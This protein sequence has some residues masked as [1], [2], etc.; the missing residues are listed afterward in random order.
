MN[1]TALILTI[2]VIIF[3]VVIAYVSRFFP[4]TPAG[5]R[6]ENEVSRL[7]AQLP[8]D[9][10]NVF[11][12][13]MFYNNNRSTQIDHIVV[14]PF[15]VFV[16]ETKNYSGWISGNDR[17][18]EWVK[19]NYGKKYRFRNPTMQNYGHVRFLTELLGIDEGVF[20]S[21]VVFTTRANLSVNTN[22]AVIYTTQLIDYIYSFRNCVLKQYEVEGLSN[23]I[24]LRNITDASQRNYHVQRIQR[25]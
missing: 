20:H 5:K 24:S 8:V 15:G 13:V 4:F 22:Q 16:I 9:R 11:N 25:E 23:Y 12:D 14:S 1:N 2:C 18:E 7:L 19:S 3:V 17:S 6:G 10:Y 21:V